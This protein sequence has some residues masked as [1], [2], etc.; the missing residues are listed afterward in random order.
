MFNV[1]IKTE[2]DEYLAATADK[3]DNPLLFLVPWGNAVAKD[4]RANARAKGGRRFWREIARATRVRTVSPNAVEVANWHVAGGHKQTGGEIRPKRAKALTIPI[5]DEAKG[6][7]AGEFEVG[8]RDLFVLPKDQGD[9]TGI[10]GYSDNGEFHALFVLRKRVVQEA[11]PWWPDARRTTQLG[12]I[13]ADRFVD[14]EIG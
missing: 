13:E 14:K 12:I 2:V 9:T 6:K 5:S 11:E 7:R 4:A 1:K 8:G 10:L 3:L